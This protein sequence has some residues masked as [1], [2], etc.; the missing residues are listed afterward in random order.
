MPVTRS[1]AMFFTGGLLAGVAAVAAYPWLKKQYDTLREQSSSEDSAMPQAS[2]IGRKLSETVEEFLKNAPGFV[3]AG[4]SGLHAG[5]EAATRMAQ[6]IS[7][8]DGRNMHESPCSEPNQ[9]A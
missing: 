8:R 4:K 6:T 7:Q 3:D 9:A 2:E 1:E 5:F